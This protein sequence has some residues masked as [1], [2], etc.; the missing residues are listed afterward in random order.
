MLQCVVVQFQVELQYDQKQRRRNDSNASTI[1]N[2]IPGSNKSGNFP[3]F[4]G[5]NSQKAGTQVSYNNAMEMVPTAGKLFQVLPPF[6]NDTADAPQGGIQKGRPRSGGRGGQP[7]RDK[8][9]QHL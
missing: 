9:K 7:K 4:T 1:S 6:G 8:V 2:P 3:M 5:T